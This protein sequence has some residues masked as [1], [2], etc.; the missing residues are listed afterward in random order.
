LLFTWASDAVASSSG[1]WPSRF[2]VDCVLARAQSIGDLELRLDEL[3]GVLGDSVRVEEGVDVNGNDIDD[4]A[5]DIGVF[6]PDVERLGGRDESRVSSSLQGGGAGGDEAREVAGGAD[7]AVYGFV[8]EDDEF[9]EV[10]FGPS[11]K[12]ADLFL[13]ACKS[14]ISADEN[15]EN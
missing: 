9:D 1:R 15:S 11:S 3:P 12:I 5:E 8:S 6:L 13:G 14:G 4:A 10:P 7:L 2:R